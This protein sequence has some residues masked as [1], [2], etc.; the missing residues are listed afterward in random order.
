MKI[1]LLSVF[2]PYRGGIAQFGAQLYRSLEKSNDVK[3]YNFKRQY[4]KLLF[5]G[6]TQL[7]TENDRAD[8][9]PNERLLDSIQ[10]LSYSN[11]AKAIRAF[12]PDVVISQYWMT[13]FGPAIGTVN[14]KLK[15]KKRIAII[16]N[17]IPHEGRFFDAPANRYFLKHTDAFVVMSD[18]VRDD[19]L[20]LK[21]NAQFLRVDHPVYNQ[22]GETKSKEE[23]LERLQIPSTRKVLLF[24]GLI[25]DYKGLDI[26]L[27][28]MNQLPDDYHLIIAGE[29]Y[30]DFQKYAD[31][32]DEYQ[33][34]ARV[35]LY[36]EYIPDDEV[37]WYFSAADVCV[38]PYKSATQSGVTAVSFQFEVPVIATDVG[39]LKE[40]IEDGKTGAI[41]SKPDAALLCDEI[42]AFFD[43]RK[44]SEYRKS[45]KH[46][47]QEH[48]WENFS[49]KLLQFVKG[50][51]VSKS[52]K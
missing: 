32:I 36:L 10:P 27:K 28:S 37:A 18:Q 17:M 4:P 16:H 8:Q 33:L 9:I 29:P 19:L 39:G 22:F 1:A 7:V 31:L 23:A 11:T 42:Q 13:F 24:F 44:G 6:S 26:L 48:S 5:P 21:P 52:S 35:S 45:I 20:S 41:V 2:Y 14:K 30:G 3:A 34:K 38:L 46:W 12:D 47:K 25:R 43:D 49:E 51:D 15:G 50:V 40:T